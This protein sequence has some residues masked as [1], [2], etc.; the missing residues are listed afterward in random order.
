MAACGSLEHIFEKPLQPENPTLLEPISPWNHIKSIDSS[1]SSPFSELFEKLHFKGTNADGDAP[2]PPSSLSLSL[3]LSLSSSKNS[4]SSSS[5]S[6]SSPF[7]QSRDNLNDDDDEGQ[8]AAGQH[9]RLQS[10]P[11]MNSDRLSLCTEGLGFES[12]DAVEDLIYNGDNDNNN[13]C[14]DKSKDRQDEE[15]TRNYGVRNP[16][17]RSRTHQETSFPPPIS[18]IGSHGKPWVCFK[19]YRREGR[20]ILKEVRIL[21][22]E[23]L[24][25]CRDNGRLR[26]RFVSSNEFDDGVE[27]EDGDDDE[28]DDEEKIIE[29]ENEGNENKH[30]ETGGFLQV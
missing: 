30:I 21:T 22:Q 11:S 12:F 26:L 25:A 5:S 19:P 1:S 24:H 9:G 14:N 13:V 4:S 23:F 10:F 28:D 15:E 27:E 16:L 2:P 20:F 3:T 17:R 29:A 8:I 18:C 7:P 6:M